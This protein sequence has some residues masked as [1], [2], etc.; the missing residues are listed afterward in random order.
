LVFSSCTEEKRETLEFKVITK[1][2]EGG[3]VRK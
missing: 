2:E 3:R 1:R